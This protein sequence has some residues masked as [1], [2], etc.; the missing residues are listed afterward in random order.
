MAAMAGLFAACGAATPAAAAGQRR[1]SLT[2]G[3]VV[4]PA[5]QIS[6]V[7]SSGAEAAVRCSSGA[8]WTAS[9]PQPAPS[10]TRSQS[11]DES[12]AYITVSY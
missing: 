12:I 3:V 6:T 5:C 1:T 8:S 10:E 9:M 7:A 11:P 2:I 4:R